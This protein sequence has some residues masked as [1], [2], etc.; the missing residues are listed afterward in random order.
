MIILRA[1]HP[2]PS[3]N[4]MLPR[5]G[6]F[7]RD[8]C[9]SSSPVQHRSPSNSADEV[10]AIAALISL[11]SFGSESTPQ[12]RSPPLVA[13]S[14]TSYRFCLPSSHVSGVNQR[15]ASHHHSSSFSSA[16]SVSS[17]DSSFYGTEQHVGSW[18]TGTSSL[19]LPEDDDVLSPLHCF[20]RKYCVE[21]FTASAEDVA[22]PRYGKS[23][24]G[25]IVV[26]QV[27]IRCLHCH[28]LAT[29]RPERAVCFPSSLRNIY[30]SMETWQRRHSAACT[31]IPGW[32][33]KE[34]M[35]LMNSSRNSAGGRRQ[36]WEDAAKRLGMVDTPQGV[37]FARPPGT[38]SPIPVVERRGQTRA[39]KLLRVTRPIVSLAD[40]PLVT[41]FLYLLMEQMQV[42]H[43]TEEDRSGGRSKV[44]D[45]PVGFPG[46]QCKHC[47]GKAGYGRYF[48]SSQ[49]ALA[50]AN[51]DRNTYNHIM[52][53]RKCPKNVQLQLKALRPESSKNKRG[54]RKLFFARVW[55]RVH[56]ETASE[57]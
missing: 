29:K 34:M 21:V 9:L 7:R 20:M 49:D 11:P 8:F 24:G 1:Q 44:K 22:I 17:V 52:K 3:N 26:G 47:C 50:L 19:A 30:H 5:E 53:C 27:G 16:S 55:D 28:Q 12:L 54:S 37:R 48:P 43:F 13:S 41:D 33:R 25:K 6:A 45:F 51:S 31:E 40:K 18:Y 14:T 38:E 36:Y 56:Q 42:C 23:H 57:R 46:I 4:I 10:D 2:E 32:V 39:E 15:P 35:A